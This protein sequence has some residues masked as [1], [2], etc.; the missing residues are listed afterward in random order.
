MF[1]FATILFIQVLC[2]MEMDL[3]IPSFPELQEVF[4]LSPFMVQMTLSVNFFAFCICSLFAGALGDR[5]NRRTILI[6]GLCIF[7]AGSFLCVLAPNYF[8][9][10]LGRALQGIGIAAPAILSFP[11]LL[12][13][14][15]SEKQA[16]M[17]GMV[18]GVKTLAM[19]IAP[20]IGS[21]VNL[22]FSW[23]GNFSVLLG[24]GIFCLTASFF[25]IPNKI[26]NDL[27][28]LSLKTYLPLLKSQKFLMFFFG[29]SLLTVGY[30][31]FMGMAPIFYMEDMAV[32]L[33]HFGYYQGL[34]SL[35]FAM[36][37]IMSPPIFK[38][39]GQ[40]R[41]FYFGMG[42]CFLSA[43]LIMG[44]VLFQVHQ[45]KVITAVLVLFSIGIVFPIN[46]LYPLSL[47]LLPDTKGRSAGLGQAIFLLLTA[48]LLGLV[49]YFYNGK[50][51][52]IGLTMFISI[53]L[54]IM[55]IQ[56]IIKKKWLTFENKRS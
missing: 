16:G 19:A 8:L 10:I 7:V 20:V 11:V 1:K 9:L 41:C 28:S 6:L 43:V 38:K 45:P 18:N 22:Y 13:N 42:T 44:L 4:N 31:V 47:D 26:G 14:C 24:L 27:V 15:S 50:F 39:F 53:V 17:M 35:T 56:R 34:L 46:I 55:L 40:K 32:P 25:T 51:M 37:C 52:P 54:S 3:F 33:N 49:G 2:G 23:R 5:Y 21:F 36:V 30:W 29:L 12:E 48:S